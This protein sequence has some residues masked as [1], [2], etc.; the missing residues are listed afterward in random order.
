M[1][2]ELRAHAEALARRV[3]QPPRNEYEAFVARLFAELLHINDVSRLDDFF[4]RGGD[5]LR[6]VAVLARI[7]AEFG[8]K[9]SF[10]TLLDHADV[11]GLAAAVCAG[12]RA[13]NDSASA[14]R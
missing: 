6:A 7:E 12:Q 11:A 1:R 3:W 5:S 10:D 2:A 8:V 14:D 4:E 13:G 9:V